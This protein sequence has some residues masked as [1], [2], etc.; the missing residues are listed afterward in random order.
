VQR[1]PFSFS[2]LQRLAM[3]EKSIPDHPFPARFLR[4]TVLSVVAVLL[5]AGI[6]FVIRV[7]WYTPA[8]PIVPTIAAIAPRRPVV[9]P[10]MNFTDVTQQSGIQFQFYHAE[11]P[12]RLLPETMTGGVAIFDFDGDGKQDILFLNAR[13]WPGQNKGPLPTLAL[14]RNLGNFRFKDVTNQVGLDVPLFAMGVCIGDLDNDGWPDIFVSAMGGNKL[15]KNLGGKRFQDITQ[16]SGVGGPDTFPNGDYESFLQRQ[17]PLAFPTSATFFDYDGDGKLDLLVGHYIT[18][19]PEMDLAIHSKLGGLH[20]T[21]GQPIWFAGAQPKLYRNVDGM[22]F[23]DVSASVGMQ[24]FVQEGVGERLTRKNA[25]KMLGVCVADVNHDGWPDVLFACDTTRNLFFLNVPDGKGGRRFEE[26][27]QSWNLAYADSQA[28]GGMGI[29]WAEYHPNQ[30]AFAI[31]NFAKEPLSFFSRLDAGSNRFTDRCLAEGLFGYSRPPVK[32]GTFFFDYDLDGRLD[33]LTCN[34]HLEPDIARL[35]DWQT[36]AQAAQLFW[37]T[38]ESPGAF[39]P[40]TAAAAGPDL[41]KP[42][43]GRGSAYA[44]LDSDGDLDLVLV[45]LQGQPLILRNDQTLGN[46]WIRL[47]LEGDGKRCNRSALGVEVTVDANGRLLHRTVGGARG[48]LSQSELP[49]TIGLGAAQSVDR[50]T[51]RYPGQHSTTQVLTQVS[52]HQTIHVRMPD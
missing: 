3:S 37:N 27:G 19:S 26:A 12:E 11:T 29:D 49:L 34:G 40:V 46:H 50:I 15:F 28:R 24:A 45:N 6:W 38:G 48:Y 41:F 9:L 10:K 18:W 43:V 17:Q 13:P 4:W 31:A 33:L 21:Y 20:R 5:G 16:E 23:E 25:G 42:I 22:H 7:S 47:V 1:I 2:F 32:F 52:A 51:I 30:E 44:D 36:Y 39:E 14:Y 8:T 35:E